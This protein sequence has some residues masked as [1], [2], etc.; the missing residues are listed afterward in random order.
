[1]Q[2][3]IGNATENYFSNQEFCFQKKTWKQNEY[4]NANNYV[5]CDFYNQ[6]VYYNCFYWV[7]PNIWTDFQTSWQFT[8]Y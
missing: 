4:D 3:R 1:M 6:T 7:V 2:L 5:L 8:K